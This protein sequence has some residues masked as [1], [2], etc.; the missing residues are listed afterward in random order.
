MRRLPRPEAFGAA[1]RELLAYPHCT[2]ITFIATR[3]EGHE[4]VYYYYTDCLHAK[5]CRENQPEHAS[6]AEISNLWPYRR[7]TNPSTPGYRDTQSC[8]PANGSCKISSHVPRIAV[9][10]LD[11]YYTAFPLKIKSSNTNP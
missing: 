6:Q 8:R 1:Y 9:D 3:K 5:S 4:I 11:R 7:T 2:F 10:C